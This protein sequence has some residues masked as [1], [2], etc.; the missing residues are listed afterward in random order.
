MFFVCKFY[1][2]VVGLFSANVSNCSVT[3]SVVL[4][5]SCFGPFGALSA[6]WPST[7]AYCQ[8]AFTLL[9]EEGAILLSLEEME[10]LS[11]P[12]LV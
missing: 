9:C 1:K 4:N 5:L 11:I 8:M 10:F 6:L 12:H 3:W 7:V 2:I